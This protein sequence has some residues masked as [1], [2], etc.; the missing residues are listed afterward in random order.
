MFRLCSQMCLIFK[1]TRDGPTHKKNL[2]WK[3]TRKI[4]LPEC[5]AWFKIFN[6]N[7]EEKKSKYISH[8]IREI[9]FK[10]NEY[11]YK[12]KLFNIEMGHKVVYTP[13]SFFYV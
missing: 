1:V 6:H 8:L 9:H 3:K 11:W 4:R 7:F 10:Q 12:R 5:P 13:P 2:I